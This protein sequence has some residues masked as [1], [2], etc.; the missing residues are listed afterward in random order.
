MCNAQKDRARELIE[1]FNGKASKSIDVD[2]FFGKLADLGAVDEATFALLKFEDL[3]DAGLPRILARQVATDA[4]RV[5]ADRTSPTQKATPDLVGISP[6]KMRVRDLLAVCVPGDKEDR[7][8][9]ELGKRVGDKRFVVYTDDAMTKIDLDAAM[10]LYEDLDCGESEMYQDENGVRAVYKIGEKP[11]KLRDEHPMFPGE[12]L[13][14]NGFSMAGVNWGDLSLRT[15]QLVRIASVETG[16][17]VGKDEHDVFDIVGDTSGRLDRIASRCPKAVLRHKDL[18][19]AGQ[20]PT[21]K[22]PMRPVAV[23][24]SKPNNPFGVNR[25]T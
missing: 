3:E 10:V 1:S 13:R 18:E 21:L 14:P 22:A 24:K 23:A 19:A 17:L 6:K 15:R 2:A 25:A 12:F 9:I 11:I 20:L 16:E 7:Y 5:G 8:T 4:F